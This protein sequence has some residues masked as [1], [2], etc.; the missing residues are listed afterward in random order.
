MKTD[1][2]RVKGVSLLLGA[3]FLCAALLAEYAFGQTPFYQGKTITVIA[4]TSP[5]G[6]G[7]LRVRAVVPF[8]R[9]H[10]P[11]NPTIVIEYMDGGGGRKGNTFL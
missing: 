10:T 11:G 5:G 9:K 7:D 8:L 3:W 4:T 6:T 2:D 1:R